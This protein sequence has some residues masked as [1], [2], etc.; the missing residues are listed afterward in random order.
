[1]KKLCRWLGVAHNVGQSMCYWILIKG[2]E[3]SARSTVIPI[4]EHDLNSI[5][6]REKMD[7]FTKT[8]ES[9]IGNYESAVIDGE[10]INT[11]SAYKDS[12]HMND[13]DD[14]ITYPW[15][16]ELSDIPLHDEN[17][18]T[19][20]DLDKYIGV[21]IKLH[22]EN[23]VPVL[24]RV[25][26]RKRDQNGMVIGKRN[27]NPILDSRLYHVEFP[28]GRIDEYS[29]NAIAESLY[30]SVDE[31]GFNTELLEEIT[32]HRRNDSAVKMED[33]YVL[34]NGVS[35]PVITTKG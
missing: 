21:H 17:D 27:N 24:A 33:G 4:P 28:D 5:E 14:N 18:E 9:A 32:D 6:M 29:T 10:T 12:F 34:Q 25:K 1:M 35:R 15:D 13:L 23:G 20:A 8:I 11:T 2:G 22:D 3:F 31:H 19:M 30:S 16:D 26:G 7:A